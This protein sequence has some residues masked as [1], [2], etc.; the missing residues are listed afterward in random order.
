M[1]KVLISAIILIFIVGSYWLTR[2]TFIVRGEEQL[3]T[4]VP[5]YEGLPLTIDFIHSVQKTPVQENL[6]LE[7]DLSTLQLDSTV[8]HSFGVGLPFLEEEGDWQ[9]VGND[10]ILSNMN[11]HFSTLSLRTG[12][13]TK[14]TLT[15][16]GKEYPLYE[17]FP[18][19]HRIDIYVAPKYRQFIK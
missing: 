2:P 6:H 19:G 10:F 12:L 16:D 8:Y 15:V 4:A 1:R 3:I 5:A 11:R 18:P 9:Q 7:N 14:L 17:S 13:G